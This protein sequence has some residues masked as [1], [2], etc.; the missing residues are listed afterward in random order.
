MGKLHCVLPNGM[1]FKVGTGF[2]DTQRKNP[3]KVRSNHHML[4]FLWPPLRSHC[5]MLMSFVAMQIGS[6]ITFKYQELSNSG[7][8]RYESPLL[9][10]IS[11]H[12]GR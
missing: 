2:S 4:C 3:P 6:I 7:T 1:T 9:V 10:L 11:H 5:R 12:F 8:P